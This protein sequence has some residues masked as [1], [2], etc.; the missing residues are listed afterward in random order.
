MLR[1]DCLDEIVHLAFLVQALDLVVTQICIDR[2]KHQSV[3]CWGDRRL[4][5]SLF[6]RRRRQLW[7]VW[8]LLWRMGKTD[9]LGDVERTD[10]VE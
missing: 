6:R 10:H 5:S 4:S 3:N 9:V 1:S 2:R 8:W 7:L